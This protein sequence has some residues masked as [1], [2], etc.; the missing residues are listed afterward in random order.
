MKYLKEKKR[1]YGDKMGKEMSWEASVKQAQCWWLVQGRMV[2]A[3]KF[4]SRWIF[5]GGI[6]SVC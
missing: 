3:K 2:R 6:S 4:H 1:M 5:E